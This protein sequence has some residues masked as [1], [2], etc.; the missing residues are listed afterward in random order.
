[1]PIS[2]STLKQNRQL[3]TFQGFLRIIEQ[4]F[5]ATGISDLANKLNWLVSYIKLDIYDK[6]FNFKEFKADNQKQFLERLK[7]EFPELMSEKQDTIDQL[8]K[9]TCKYQNILLLEDYFL[10]FKKHFMYI[11]QKYLKLPAVTKNKDLVEL[12]AKSLNN[13]FQDVLNLRLSLLEK[14]KIDKF[15]RS[16]VEDSYSFEHVI[17]KVVKLVS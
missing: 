4:L 10:A 15:G 14:V 8:R 9:L 12:F 2:L 17:Q 13:I 5:K 16:R 6:L 1:M 11:A 3:R 7:L